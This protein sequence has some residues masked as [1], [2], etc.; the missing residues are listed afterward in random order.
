MV[1]ILSWDVGIK[2]MSYCLLEHC[3][4]NSIKIIDWK[5]INLIKTKFD[6]LV[7]C[8]FT[9][10]GKKCSSK[11]T[12][13]TETLSGKYKGYCKKHTAIFDDSKLEE[14]INSKFTLSDDHNCDYHNK[15]NEI[16]G[17]P[18]KFQYSETELHFC[19]SHKK[20]EFNRLLKKYSLDKI[21][22]K[23]T[24]QYSTYDIQLAIVHKLDELIDGFIENDVTEVVIEN[25]PAFKSPKMKAIS[26]TLQNYF[27]IRGIID[28]SI[29]VDTVQLQAANN[30]LKINKDNTFEVL[31]RTGDDKKYKMTKK[32]GIEY[33]RIAIKDQPEMLEFMESHKKKDDLCDSY[34]QG[35]YYLETKRIKKSK[36]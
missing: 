14:K 11:P 12:Y 2:N 30:K 15:K 36:K 35:R 16:C 5:N 32:L 33:T 31:G 4:D 34:L 25:Q 22:K 26:G 8:G 9:Q 6:N 18:A 28:K 20:S 29:N 24:N 7:C 27:I 17:K 13:Y 3:E 1:K 21:K 23:T 10:K 19:T